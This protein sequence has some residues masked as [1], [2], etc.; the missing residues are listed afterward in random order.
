MN[1]SILG[2]PITADPID[3]DGVTI[4]PVIDGSEEYQ[5]LAFTRVF[6][7]DESDSVSDDDNETVK[8][9]RDVVIDFSNGEVVGGGIEQVTTPSGN[10]N[11]NNEQGH[12]HHRNHH[13]HHPHPRQPHDRHG[14]RQNKRFF[15]DQGGD[16]SKESP[17]T[18]NEL[19]TF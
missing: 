5:I 7:I 16:T 11:E 15:V 19:G 12:H 2:V 17:I 9:P 18:P 1:L 10:E 3:A 4:I 6:Y 14:S 13:H 8:K